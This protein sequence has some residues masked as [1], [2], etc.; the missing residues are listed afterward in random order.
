MDHNYL[1]AYDADLHVAE[2]YDQSETERDDVELIRTLIGNAGP[3]KIL[4]PFCGTGR[5]LLPL[6][7]D[8]HAVLGMDQSTG[9]LKRLHQKVQELPPETQKRITVLQADVLCEAWP[10]GFD[11]VILGCNCFYELATPQEQAKCIAQ[12]FQSLHPGGHLFIDNHHMEGELAPSWQNLGVVE[13]SLR[14]VCSD[15]AVVECTRETV[16]YDASRRLA[17]FRRRTQVT[18]A[19]GEVIEQTSIQQKHPVSKGEVHG[20]LEKY[21]FQVKG[22]YGNHAGVLYKDESAHAIFWAERMESHS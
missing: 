4:E 11:L 7:L 3:L 1:N 22:T 19:N 5:I 2:V 15:G 20:W 21:D 10:R 6:A 13:P 9:M 14:G 17:R 12:A 16:W 8:G 18:L